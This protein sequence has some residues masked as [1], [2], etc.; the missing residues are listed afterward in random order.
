MGQRVY[1]ESLTEPS[2]EKKDGTKIVGA[3]G[4]PRFW[5]QAVFVAKHGLAEI[6]AWRTFAVGGERGINFDDAKAAMEQKIDIG[7]LHRI[8]IVDV[9][10][11]V[12]TTADGTPLLNGKGAPV[13]TTHRNVF[14]LPDETEKQALEATDRN[15]TMLGTRAQAPAQAEVEATVESELDA[16]DVS[17]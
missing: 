11:V 17:A 8:A 14:V 3:N 7:D 9:D 13:M 10:P 6:R 2:D 16:A 1:V 4:K 5:F 15:L 12:A